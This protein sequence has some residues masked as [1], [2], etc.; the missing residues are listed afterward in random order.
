MQMAPL[1]NVAPVVPEVGKEDGHEEDGEGV[2][3]CMDLLRLMD[4]VLRAFEAQKPAPRPRIAIRASVLAKCM[5]PAV[6]LSCFIA[7]MA[8]LSA[9]SLAFR[10]CIDSNADC[11]SISGGRVCREN[12]FDKRDA[13]YLSSQNS[14][15]G[16]RT[17]RVL[18]FVSLFFPATLLSRAATS[19]LSFILRTQF[20]GDLIPFITFGTKKQVTHM[21]RAIL[22]FVS[23]FPL[24]EHARTLNAKAKEWNE[25]A[26]YREVWTTSFE[27]LDFYVWR[28]LLVY[29]LF[30]VCAVISAG[31]GRCLSL[32][33]HHDDHF[34]RM[35][36]YMANEKIIQLLT[37]P[38]QVPESIHVD[39][40]GSEVTLTGFACAHWTAL[41]YV[42]RVIEGLVFENSSPDLE[43]FA[44]DIQRKLASN[45]LVLCDQSTTSSPF[46]ELRNEAVD[47][48]S[49]IRMQSQTS[50]LIQQAVD[51]V[52]MPTGAI[53]GVFGSPEKP[54][55]SLSQPGDGTRSFVRARQWAIERVVDDTPPRRSAWRWRSPVKLMKR[56]FRGGWRRPRNVS[57]VQTPL[58][59]SNISSLRR[60]ISAP[61][62][63]LDRFRDIDATACEAGAEVGEGESLGD[64]VMLG[65][66]TQ[67]G[68]WRLGYYLFWNLRE[69]GR[70]FP[71]LSRSD[72]DSVAHIIGMPARTAWMLM[73]HNNDRRVTMDEVIRSVEQVYN[74]RTV[75][76]KSL[77]ESQTVVGQVQHI[78]YAFLMILLAFVATAIIIPGSISKVWTSL[79]AGLLSFSFIFG[80]SI[81]EVFENCVFLFFTHPFDLG[82]KI[83]WN[84]ETYHVRS[85]TLNF[86]NLLH[87][88]GSYVNISAHALRDAAITNVTRS[89]RVWES[90]HFGADLNTTVHQCEVAADK[91]VH[92]IATHPR[93]FGGMYRVWLR[94]SENAT[95]IDIAVHFDL[96]TNGMDAALAGEAITVMTAAF[97]D[98]LCQAGVSYTDLALAC[99]NCWHKS[100]PGEASKSE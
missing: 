18:V 90:V 89:Q 6:C 4:S 74:D 23:W 63:T 94:D 15:A 19:L 67:V 57:G 28:F 97:S 68:T 59:E 65:P 72:V 46:C 22:W 42:T 26:R 77:A 29:V 88:S 37:K 92:A 50:S 48:H 100:D 35:K 13:C 84:N 58:L 79:S 61:H 55:R 51:R 96:K 52:S 41:V 34:E 80:N 70:L 5:I 7:A 69:P 99:P 11:E 36:T 81:R 8:C 10:R 31:A 66:C 44:R 16:V 49:D 3:L 62:H 9:D 38:C 78:L 33:F 14:V 75:L 98:G 86:V 25:T 56:W 40:C 60:Y 91:V 21:V 87:T 95:K 30:T 39:I 12:G 27:H 32:V 17:W 71:D 93:L 53:S 43:Q 64:D 83:R 24:T 20:A 76:A 82:D 47:V 45:I 54:T 1:Y 2:P 85:I 73:D